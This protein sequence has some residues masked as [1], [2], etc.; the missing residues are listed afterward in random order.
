MKID[1]ALI[2]QA[3]GILATVVGLL[4]LLSRITRWQQSTD[5]RI[6][7]LERDRITQK[8]CDARHEAT[9]ER[10]HGTEKWRAAVEAKLKIIYEAVAAVRKGGHAH[11]NPHP[12]NGFPE[13]PED[14]ETETMESAP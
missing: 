13:W 7:A 5:D 9:T 1:L 2:G 4:I 12:K 10:I 6:K 11:A 3:L 8:D 14:P